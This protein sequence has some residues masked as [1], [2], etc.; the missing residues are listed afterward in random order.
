MSESIHR[1][2][3]NFLKEKQDT[4]EADIKYLTHRNSHWILYIFM[5]NQLNIAIFIIVYLCETTSEGVYVQFIQEP[6]A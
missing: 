6:T 4:N 3:T 1:T 5:T 2:G